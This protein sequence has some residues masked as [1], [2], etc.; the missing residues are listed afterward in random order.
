MKG[1]MFYSIKDLS[2]KEN[3]A[4]SYYLYKICL[5][6]EE[7]RNFEKIQVLY[8]ALVSTLGIE[9]HSKKVI[10]AVIQKH[11]KAKLLT[12]MINA[13]HGKHPF[14]DI[15][16]YY[17]EDSIIYNECGHWNTESEEDINLVR[18]VFAPKLQNFAEIV[19]C[20][21]F[22]TP[23]EKRK[24]FTIPEEI[25]VPANIIEAVKD[26]RMVDFFIDSFKLSA[27]E[28]EVLN[29]AYQSHTIKEL[30][31]VF[32]EMVNHGEENRLSLYSKCT[33]KSIKTIKS[34]LRR[35]KKL[36]SFDI[37][38]SDGDIE[39][40]AVDCIYAGDLNVFFCD[41]L[42]E[43]DKK[44]FYELNSFSVKDEESQLALRLLK[45][46]SNTNL[47]LYGSPGAGKTEYAR[48]LIRQTGFIP[49]IFKNELEVDNSEKHALSRLNCLLS[50]DKKDSVII[51]D[52]AESMLSTR[53]NFFEMLIG[54]AASNGKK[55]TVNTMLENSVNK[56]IWILNYTEPLDEST[57]RRFTYSIRFREMSR[58]ML[59][60]IADSKLNKINMSE[61]LHTELVDLCEK[62][63]V[64]G[65]SVD[66]MVKTV[67][68]M[69]LSSAGEELV[70]R[71]VQK[72]LEA[73]ST[74]LFGK[75]KMREKV[76]DSYDLSI[77][78]TSIPAADIVSM[79]MNAQSF[80]EKNG[81]EESGVRILFYG[82]SGTG[83]TELARYIAEKL[84]KKICLKRVSDI[85][86]PYVGENEQNIAKAFSE[87][88][89]SGD[90]LLF[91]EADSFFSNRQDAVRSWER[92]LVN[93]F[94]TQ[95]EEFS[96]ILIC[97]T[98]LKTIMDPAMQRRFH[99]LTEFKPLEKDG[100]KKLLGRF[101]PAYEFEKFQSEK[102]ARYDSVT[103]GD[104]G[105][106][107]GKIR[108]MNSSLVSS[109]L[110]IDELCKIQEEKDGI[111]NK[112]IGFIC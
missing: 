60:N 77:L 49:Y 83:K 38:D 54:G 80:A 19:A 15:K 108:F 17:K 70:V 100:I 11:K 34:I 9:N 20:T 102:L 23:D 48:A 91:D 111:C 66:N 98:N 37:M 1:Q 103:P 68:G 13:D 40:D 21:F 12:P 25:V 35:D 45:N 93:E 42:K 28:G 5:D 26:T 75:K 95:M 18:A 53:M 82:L 81:G 87:A 41:V 85:M 55:G 39:L 96:G 50:L 76:K 69:D 110:I 52:E 6:I 31:P 88:E 14:N 27:E 16:T 94:L 24:T 73:N 29:I 46:V 79:V 61:S 67:Q 32:N 107:A 8:N 92:T 65:A 44:E 105:S 89:S 62:Y 22:F 56:V 74:L 78:N 59:R 84:N 58:A 101:F 63:H 43:D 72:V 30:Y 4:V 36:V 3:L 90:V 104:F 99:I 33:G 97:T 57:L 71:D 2:R 106:L 51:V 86:S 47:L 7:Y 109:E 112:R 64:T 10:Q